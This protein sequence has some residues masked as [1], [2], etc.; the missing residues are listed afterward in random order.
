MSI[1]SDCHTNQEKPKKKLKI[2]ASINGS[3]INSQDEIELNNKR[4]RYI[5]NNKFVYLHPNSAAAKK[6]EEKVD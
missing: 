2:F 1:F 4:K 3:K 5:K 6:L